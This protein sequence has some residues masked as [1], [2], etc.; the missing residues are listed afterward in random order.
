M[1]GDGGPDDRGLGGDL[2]GLFV[3]NHQ[4]GLIIHDDFNDRVGHLFIELRITEPSPEFPNLLSIFK[5][6][7]LLDFC[8]ANFGSWHPILVDFGRNSYTKSHIKDRK[9]GPTDCF[10]DY[11]GPYFFPGTIACPSA[12]S[13]FI[14]PT[15]LAGLLISALVAGLRTIRELGFDGMSFSMPGRVK[16]SVVL[17][18]VVASDET[19][20]NDPLRVGINS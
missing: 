12:F 9:N 20:H 10:T 6:L 15:V 7:K 3:D 19:F 8:F 5:Y 17:V 16:E 2:L 1:I 14:L 4:I 13:P 11:F 18:S